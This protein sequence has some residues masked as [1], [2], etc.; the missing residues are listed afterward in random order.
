MTQ[1]TILF[2]PRT[3]AISTLGGVLDILVRVQAI[4]RLKKLESSKQPAGE[5]VS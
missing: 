3:S 4:D 2:S 5:A 1:P